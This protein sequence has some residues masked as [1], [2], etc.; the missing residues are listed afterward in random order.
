M[1]EKNLSVLTV[2]GISFPYFTSEE[3]IE[4]LIDLFRAQV[5]E[6]KIDE[7]IQTFCKVYPTVIHDFYE[8]DRYDDR[9]WRDIRMHQVRRLSYPLF[10][11]IF[12]KGLS[13]THKETLYAPAKLTLCC[14]LVPNGFIW[15]ISCAANLAVYLCIELEDDKTI[16]TLLDEMRNVNLRTHNSSITTLF[17]FGIKELRT[18]D[19][20][21]TFAKKY[22]NGDYKLKI[23]VVLDL[24]QVEGLSY[25]E[26]IKDILLPLVKSEPIDDEEREQLMMAVTKFI[27]LDGGCQELLSDYLIRMFR[28]YFPYMGKPHYRFIKENLST[29]A[30]NELFPDLEMWAIDSDKTGSRFCSSQFELYDAVGDSKLMLDLFAQNPYKLRGYL[31]SL[32]PQYGN[33]VTKI[34]RSYLKTE[35]ARKDYMEHSFGFIF[36]CKKVLGFEMP[37][38][39]ILA[40]YRLHTGSPEGIYFIDNKQ[41]ADICLAFVN[42]LYAANNCV[43]FSN[44]LMRYL[45][46]EGYQLLIHDI[47]EDVLWASKESMSYFIHDR[48]FPV[49]CDDIMYILRNIAN[50]PHNLEYYFHLFGMPIKLD[51]IL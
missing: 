40:Q 39:G 44:K 38:P 19:A 10:V 15:N 16:S 12:D 5:S 32:L 35:R 4:R 29:D 3:K 7:A 22:F 6:N 23:D 48:N 28:D 45:I 17:Y 37:C 34:F 18:V 31:R 20:A 24:I 2:N 1:T 46:D 36:F 50:A 41:E 9:D 8:F 14:D 33:E 42:Q 11:R 25:I 13:V 30:W 49:D 27:E 47:S 51:H 26:T 43:P 21:I